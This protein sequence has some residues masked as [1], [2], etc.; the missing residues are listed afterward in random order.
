MHLMFIDKFIPPFIDFVNQ[1][2]SLNKNL[3]VI[4]GS[5]DGRIKYRPVYPNVILLKKIQDFNLILTYFHI[6][7]KI[8]IHGLFLE[9][10][11][12]FLINQKNFPFEKIY[13][14]AWGG[15][16]Y[17]PEIQS[18]SKK[19]L[20]KKIKHIITYVKGDFDL[21]CKWYK[22]NAMYHECFMYPSNLFK[23]TDIKTNH[24]NSIN[25]QIGNSATK[26]NNH[27]EIFDKLLKYK[28]ENIKL[29]VPLSYGDESYAKI[30][31]KKGKDIFGDK[32]IPLNELLPLNDYL[33][34]LDEIDIA[35]FAHNRQ[36]GMGNII[37]LLGLGKKVYMRSDITPWQLFNEIG[38]KV[39]DI[40]NL[41]ITPIDEET[42]RKNHE[43]VKNYF[44]EERLKEQLI[45][46]FD[47]RG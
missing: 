2:F 11:I 23:Q 13:W 4:Y 36:Q 8:I 21:I 7:K 46:L 38:V 27:F 35:I 33:K 45:N 16:F 25:I 22:L 29:F 44:S 37:T 17:F 43:I 34:L 47:T 42:S 1:N 28:E 30:V 39:Y 41:D 5:G 31:I 9:D 6:A 40:K 10:V 18:E 12:N 32:F 19:R 20:I 24:H 26:T 15:D 14:V 3:F